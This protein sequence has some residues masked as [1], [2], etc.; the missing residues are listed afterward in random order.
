MTW[1]RIRIALLGL[2]FLLGLSTSSM[3]R[4]GDA[5]LFA[6]LL[7]GT[8]LTDK[9]LD[10]YYGRGVG[11]LAITRLLALEDIEIAEFYRER[12]Q[13]LVAEIRGQVIQQAERVQTQVD[14]RVETAERQNQSRVQDAQ[15]LRNDYLDDI[16]ARI[17][18]IQAQFHPK[19]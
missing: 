19:P 5:E 17:S 14:A 3:A 10:Q 13:E 8:E 6:D 11:V 2:V 12:I 4:A 15:K 7:P 16:R 18:E 9:E 1:H